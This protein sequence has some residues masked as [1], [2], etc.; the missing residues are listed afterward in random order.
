MSYINC[1]ELLG[2][3]IDYTFIE[4]GINLHFDFFFLIRNSTLAFY[5][6]ILC[7]L[8]EKKKR[9][10]IISKNKGLNYTFAIFFFNFT[11]RYEIYT[12]CQT[13]FKITHFVTQ[14]LNKLLK[15]T[16][17]IM[18]NIYQNKINITIIYDLIG[19]V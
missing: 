1:N 9:R 10:N 2:Y 12:S 3:G 17:Y 19:F 6:L 18:L 4:K 11:T 16:S 7:L 13:T 15:Y 8:Q 14:F 5:L